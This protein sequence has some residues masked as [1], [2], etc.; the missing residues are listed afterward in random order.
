[1]GVISVACYRPKPGKE[2]DL[3]ALMREHVPVLQAE[4]LATDRESIIMRAKDGT[5]V[6]IFEWA[7]REMTD[8]AH[9]NPAVL[10]MWERFNAACDYVKVSDLAESHDQWAS[11]EPLDL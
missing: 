2:H 6:E 9:S 10:A 7:S 8:A 4:S 5:I 11:F 3:E 1:M